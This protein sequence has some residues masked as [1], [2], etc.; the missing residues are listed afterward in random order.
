MKKLILILLIVFGNNITSTDFNQEYFSK[1]FSTAPLDLKYPGA[2][3][4]FGGGISYS[5]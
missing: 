5:F 4:V 1:E 3:A 2:P